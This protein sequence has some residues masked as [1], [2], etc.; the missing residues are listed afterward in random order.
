M[1]L[2]SELYF[3]DTDYVNELTKEMDLYL[4]SSYKCSDFSTYI[5]RRKGSNKKIFAIRYPG[6]TRGHVKVNHKNEIVEIKL[7]EDTSDIYKEN[8]KDCFEKYLGRRLIF[9]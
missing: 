4:K 8:I 5:F 7:Y 6:A 1:D 3:T 9:N 2:I